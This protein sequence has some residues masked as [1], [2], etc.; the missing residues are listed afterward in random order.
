[1]PA[2]LVFVLVKM[3]VPVLRIE[4]SAPT[5][6]CPLGSVTAPVMWLVPLVRGAAIDQTG[7]KTAASRN[8]LAL[9]IMTSKQPLLARMRTLNEGEICRKPIVSRHYTYS[10]RF[11]R[12]SGCS[13]C[14]D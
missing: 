4:T 7:N 14:R 13:L 10:A 3:F 9:N 8:R 1:M 2:V 12:P 11:S 5:R 6:I